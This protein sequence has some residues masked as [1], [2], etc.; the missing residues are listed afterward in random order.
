MVL[1]GAERT[2][3]G[4]ARRRRARTAGRVLRVMLGILMR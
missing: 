1:T 4:E 3:A 2:V